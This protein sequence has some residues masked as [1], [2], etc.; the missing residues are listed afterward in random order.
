VSVYE[1]A[2]VHG[3]GIGPEV[4]QAAVDVLKAVRSIEGLLRFTEYRAGS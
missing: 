4:C 1:T 3:H 2:L